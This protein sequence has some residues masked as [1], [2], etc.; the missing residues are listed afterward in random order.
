[1]LKLLICAEKLIIADSIT[2][3]LLQIYFLL[4]HCKNYKQLR[5]LIKLQTQSP[6]AVLEKRC[7]EN[8]QQIYTSGRLLLKLVS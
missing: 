2:S 1:M 3:S 7:F 4:T 8:M 6:R 5:F